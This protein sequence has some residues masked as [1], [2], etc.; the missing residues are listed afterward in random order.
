MICAHIPHNGL[1]TTAV[2]KYFVY[3][4]SFD[5]LN[6]IEKTRQNFKRCQLAKYGDSIV[7]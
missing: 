4:S 1:T 3:I 5:V 2:G 7:R 6:A